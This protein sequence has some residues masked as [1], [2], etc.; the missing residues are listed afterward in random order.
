[1]KQWVHLPVLASLA[2]AM[3]S[4]PAAA[5]GSSRSTTPVE[6]RR[7]DA[8]ASAG[9]LTLATSDTGAGWDGWQQKFLFR[10]DLGRY[11]TTH[12]KTDISASVSTAG[13]D[14]E[15][16]RVPVPGSST[17]G[18]GYTQVTHRIVSVAPAV[19]WQFRENTFMH[20]YVSG[21]VDVGVRQEHRERDATIRLGTLGYQLPAVDERRSVVQ[22]RPF[23]AGGFKSYF[24]RSV[25]VRTEGR[26]AFAQDGVRQVALTAG[27]GVD[28]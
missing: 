27:I 10:G 11:W 6:F 12:L 4:G 20:P 8:G 5:Q 26:V 28:F 18:Y 1:V 3:A 23:V 22:A 16:E 2:L 25:Y 7:W 15:I 24:S 17:P 19:T 13:T 14:Y 9:L 21:G